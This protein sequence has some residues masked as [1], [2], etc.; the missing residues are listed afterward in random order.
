[1]EEIDIERPSARV[2]GKMKKGHKVRICPAKGEGMGLMIHPERFNHISRTFAKGAGLHIALSPEEIQ[3]NHARGIWG[4]IKKGVKSLGHKAIDL[5]ATYAPQLATGA[6]S[7]LALATGQPELLP[8][9]GM[10][11]AYLGSEIGKAGS[12]YAHSELDRKMSPPSRSPSIDM[13]NAHTGQNMGHL[14][15]ATM[16]SAMANMSLAEMEAM[17]ARKRASMG[18]VE[19]PR[20]DTSGSRSLAPYTD[21]VPEG[22]GLYAQG[23][24]LGLRQHRHRRE[25]S[26]IGIHGNLLGAGLPPALM[27][28]PY[29][30]NFQFGSRLPPAYQAFAKSGHGL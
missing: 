11:G 30:A 17:V 10:A 26:S 20:L 16:G 29:S 27:S 21:A 25:M 7:G 4:T 6:L 19:Q 18:I 23:H 3:H 13:L 9:A 5:G 12:K 28:Q 24:G 22:G 1:M 8:L 2:L 15:K 14:A